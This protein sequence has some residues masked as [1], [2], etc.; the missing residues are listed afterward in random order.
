M[1]L[2]LSGGTGTPKLLQ[3]AMRVL[4]EENIA[5]IVNTAEDVIVLNQYVSPDIDTVLYTFS[6]KI[7]EERWYGVKGD[8]FITHE[9]LLSLGVKEILKIGDID[10]AVKIQKTIL[11]SELS[12][13]E[14]V[15]FQRKAMGI[16][17]K[18]IPMSND[19]VKT[20]IVT[21]N[22]EMTYHEFWVENRGRPRVLD[23][24]F[25]GINSAKAP[26]EAISC[27]KNAEKIVI[28]PSNPI[29]SIMPIL[30]V[31]EIGREIKRK[32]AVAVS[33]IIGKSAVSGPLNAFMSAKGYEISC[34][35][36]AQI[37]K[38]YIKKIIVDEKD[39]EF[40]KKI[41]EMGIECELFPILMKTMEDKVEV[42]KKV[43]ED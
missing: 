29:T 27:I 31:R 16:R 13:S 35:G 33:P 36:V 15:E 2:F 41:E 25:E 19:A 5:V 11:L 43:I 20:K 12:L 34:Y 8:S 42:A 30:S 32:K 24:Y 4:K 23:I 7:D 28:G 1:I 39:Y 21:E 22:G 37:Y 10:R 38:D 6:G 9:A 3:G 26:E 14:A 18:I 40:K 17:A